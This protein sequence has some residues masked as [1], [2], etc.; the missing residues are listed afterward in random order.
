ME[1][2]ESGRLDALHASVSPPIGSSTI[3][4]TH[5]LPLYDF[6][7]MHINVMPLLT[8]N[9]QLKLEVTTQ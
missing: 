7:I 2:R 1:K 5:C 9:S 6:A 8:T 3:E 4:T